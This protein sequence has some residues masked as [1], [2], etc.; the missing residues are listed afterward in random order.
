M[1]WTSFHPKTFESE[2][3]F[4][5]AFQGLTAKCCG[6]GEMQLVPAVTLLNVDGFDILVKIP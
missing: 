2:K 6:Q 4:L 5:H 3:G 1:V